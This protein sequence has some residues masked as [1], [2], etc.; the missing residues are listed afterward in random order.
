MAIT[1]NKETF[2]KDRILTYYGNE[3]FIIPTTNIAFIYIENSIIYVI[4]S[5]G[6]K[7]ISN[8]SLNTIFLKLNRH[9]FFRINRQIIINIS[10]IS[11]IIKM[12]L[13]LK[14]QTSPSCQS[15]I[16]VRKNKIASFKNW[17]NG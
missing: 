14:V 17:I 3:F 9:Q 1:S 13:I 7:S 6:K 10:A 8:E 12:G 15:P 5:D 11:K 2:S 16:F 4:N